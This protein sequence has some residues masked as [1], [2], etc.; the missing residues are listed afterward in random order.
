MKRKSIDVVRKISRVIDFSEI[1][2]DSD[3]WEFFS[4]G[5]LE[6]LGYSIIQQPSRGQDHGRDMI[7][8]NNT[9]DLCL[10]SC[11]NFIGSYK[12][13]GVNDELNVLE[14]MGEC[15]TA[16]FIGMY[17][18]FAS[19][20]LIERLDGLKKNGKIKDGIVYSG[21]EI[22][23]C[24]LSKGMSQLISRYMPRSYHKLKAPTLLFDR[25]EK[26]ECSVC[27]KDLLNDHGDIL[28]TEKSD[29]EIIVVDNICVTCKGHCSYMQ[30]A[31]IYEEQNLIPLSEELFW[32]QNSIGF[33]QHYFRIMQMLKST[34]YRFTDRAWNFEQRILLS[35]SQKVMR[36]VSQDDR[37][38]M[39]HLLSISN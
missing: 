30:E 6:Q 37:E 19:T 2:S 4:A 17:S 26:L 24:V 16:I 33:T 38:M 36:E 3:E 27:G 22:E 35:I 5:F 8:R 34:E 7:V 28:W 25:I 23:S 39:S 10:V 14:R 12:S 15:N 20:E 13:V 18:T 9:G 21:R 31:K 29:G 1:P 32:L 11:K